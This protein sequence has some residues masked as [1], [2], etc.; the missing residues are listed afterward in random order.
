[1]HEVNEHLAN[2]ANDVILDETPVGTIG[3][4]L[5]DT[6]SVLSDNEPEII[7][8]QVESLTNAHDSFESYIDSFF[9]TVDAD[10]WTARTSRQFEIGMESIAK[11]GGI[12][13][14]SLGFEPSFEDVGKTETPAEHREKSE[15][16]SK[17]VVSRIWEAIKRAFLRVY[18]FF[19]SFFDKI[20]R[21]EKWLA[22]ADQNLSA[23]LVKA[24]QQGGFKTG[25][26]DK[27]PSWSKYLM[28]NGAATSASNALKVTSDSL[29]KVSDAFGKDT[30]DAADAELAVIPVRIKDG[31]LEIN[32]PSKAVGSLS[33]P[34]ELPGNVRLEI[35]GDVK[36]ILSVK[37]VKTQKDAT[38]SKV[39]YISEAESTRFLTNFRELVSTSV[40]MGDSFYRHARDYEEVRKALR[41]EGVGKGKIIGDLTKLLSHYNS[42]MRM[43]F[44]ELHQVAKMAY[45]HGMASVK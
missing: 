23:K 17:G 16:K 31:K 29:L 28:I 44:L 18:E 35:S 3:K 41:E 33:W 43:L 25:S 24:R 19:I 34:L 32:V 22:K 14:E 26:V 8:K 5:S 21:A 13:L 11:A 30:A 39:E 42:T 38:I 2:L 12:S 10:N 40:K 45:D 6:V 7:S 1:M 4:E 20:K 9:K 36:D 37:L 27:I 15:E